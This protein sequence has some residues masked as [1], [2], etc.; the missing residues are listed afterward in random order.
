VRHYGL[1]NGERENFY[2]IGRS[3]GVSGERIRQLVDICLESYR[4]PERKT[5]FITA[6]GTIPKYLLRN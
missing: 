6:T 4:Q 1:I 3:V 5:Q 2:T